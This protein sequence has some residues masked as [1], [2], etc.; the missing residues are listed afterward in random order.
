MFFICV[1]VLMYNNSYLFFISLFFFFSGIMFQDITSLV[2]N[3]R[4]FKDTIDIFV[5]RYKNMGISVVAGNFS[6]HF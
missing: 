2:S 5:D 3:H 4:V 1:V 6:L